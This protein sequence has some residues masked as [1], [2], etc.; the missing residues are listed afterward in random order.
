MRRSF[1]I[2]FLILSGLLAASTLAVAD[3]IKPPYF[4]VATPE[5]SDPVFRNSVIMMV[6]TIQP[7]LAAGVIINEPTG[8]TAHEVFPHFPALKDDSSTAYFGGPIDDGTPTIAVRAAHAPEKA[9]KIVDD[10]YVTTDAAVIA[11]AL[12]DH[13]GPADLRIFLGRAQWG[14][15]QLHYE[16][17]EGAWYV[18]PANADQIF[19]VDPAHLWRKLVERSQL[20]ET[21]FILPF[22]RVWQP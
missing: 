10:V 18:V 20:Q 14:P 6:P 11:Q 15:D 22:A 4:L 2:V 1:G 19:S 7:P 12:K 3:D 13:A 17:L 5:M 9:S 8:T 21:N 16:I